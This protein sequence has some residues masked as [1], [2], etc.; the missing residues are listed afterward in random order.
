MSASCSASPLEGRVSKF[1]SFDE[2]ENFTPLQSQVGTV[3]QL[4]VGGVTDTVSKTCSTASLD[5]FNTIS[6]FEVLTFT[7]HADQVQGKTFTC[8]ATVKEI[9]TEKSW[10]YNACL[11]CSKR[12]YA[13]RDRWACL[14][15]GKCDT[16]KHMDCKVKTGMI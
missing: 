8:I 16:P 4:I 9:L 15:H 1:D 12:V 10:Y 3:S 7:S 11:E 5:R 13:S 2:F 6:D 14:S